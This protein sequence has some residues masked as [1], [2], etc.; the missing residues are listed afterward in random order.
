M[1]LAAVIDWPLGLLISTGIVL[2]AVVVWT[3]FMGRWFS[4]AHV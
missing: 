4:R 3:F 2:P 1:T